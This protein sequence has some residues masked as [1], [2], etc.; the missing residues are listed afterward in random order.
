LLTAVSK[1]NSITFFDVEKNEE[2]HIVQTGHADQVQS[3]SWNFDSSRFVT[4]SKDKKMKIFDPRGN[5]AVSVRVL[6]Q[7]VLLSRSSCAIYG[8]EEC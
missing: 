2:C 6:H 1:D 5:T 7:L 8:C 3:V 4:S